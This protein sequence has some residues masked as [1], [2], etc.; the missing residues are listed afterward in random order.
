MLDLVKIALLFS[1]VFDGV[2]H[3]VLKNGTLDISFQSNM[4]IVSRNNS[5]YLV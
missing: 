1:K 3:I 4:K 2:Q 5:K